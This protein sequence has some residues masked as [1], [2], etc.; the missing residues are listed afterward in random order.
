M[1]PYLHAGRL[2]GLAALRPDRNPCRPDMASGVE[3][4]YDV[5][6]V[7]GYVFPEATPEAMADRFGA[8]A[9]EI[10]TGSEAD[11]EDV[12]PTYFRTQSR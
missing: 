10:A 8:A 9:T 5:A 6:F 4:G 12:A 11:A 1:K 7:Y 3:Q 2:R